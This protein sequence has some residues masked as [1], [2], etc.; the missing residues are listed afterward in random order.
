M[1]MVNKNGFKGCQWV[2]LI[3]HL[4]V[5]EYLKRFVIQVVGII[6]QKNECLAEM[7]DVV[8]RANVALVYNVASCKCSG[9]KLTDLNC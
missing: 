7:L 6:W 3:C 8:S 2:H 9:H 4:S 1:W 5:Y